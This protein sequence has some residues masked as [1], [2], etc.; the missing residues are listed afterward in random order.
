MKKYDC[1]FFDRDGTVNY[2]PG[3]ISKLKYFKFFEFAI[4]AM[5]Q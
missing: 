4:E 1:I 5:T 3:Y 2:D